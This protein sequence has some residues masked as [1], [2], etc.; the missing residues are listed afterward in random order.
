MGYLVELFQAWGRHLEGDRV[1]QAG[2]VL[3]EAGDDQGGGLDDL[4]L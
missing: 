2:E 1:G 3:Q 4:V